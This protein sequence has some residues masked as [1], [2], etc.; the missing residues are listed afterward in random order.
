MGIAHNTRVLPPLSTH[1][2]DIIIHYGQ[3]EWNIDITGTCQYA[4]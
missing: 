1:T 2:A 3:N 4:K